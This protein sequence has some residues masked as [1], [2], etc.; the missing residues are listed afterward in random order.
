VVLQLD[1]FIISYSIGRATPIHTLDNLKNPYVHAAYNAWGQ[2]NLSYP[3]APP[4]DVNVFG[5][6]AR[7][8]YKTD[9][10]TGLV[11]CQNRY[12]D[13]A[14][15][16]WLTR[17]PISYSGGINLYGYCSGGPVGW[18]DPNGLKGMAHTV[19]QFALG[20]LD[21]FNPISMIQGFIENNAFTDPWG[22]KRIKGFIETMNQFGSD[23]PR[24]VGQVAGTLAGILIPCRIGFAKL[25]KGGRVRPGPP[26]QITAPRAPPFIQGRPKFSHEARPGDHGIRVREDGTVTSYQTY[27]Q[28]GFS[29]YRTDYDSYSQKRND[30]SYPH[31]VESIWDESGRVPGGAP[32]FGDRITGTAPGHPTSM[33]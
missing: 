24:K 25:G 32:R 8:G 5:Y 23:Y 18:A 31:W 4:A 27:D 3:A 26:P 6:N 19:G 15:G 22:I 2:R 1:G 30:H 14:N 20:V 12:Y 33:P 9:S 16:R 17:D 11:Y 10:E 21:A 28:D 13:P 29:Q 7:W